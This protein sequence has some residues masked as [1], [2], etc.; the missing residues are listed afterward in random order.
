MIK[1]FSFI[2]ISLITFGCQNSNQNEKRNSLNKNEILDTFS[3]NKKW[4]NITLKQLLGIKGDSLRKVVLND[5]NSFAK[6]PKD[7]LVVNFQC[8]D[9]CGNSPIERVDVSPLFDDI[10]KRAIEFGFKSV[11][12][13]TTQ[14]LLDFGLRSYG[15]LPYYNLDIDAYENKVHVSQW[16]IYKPKG[17]ELVQLLKT[18]TIKL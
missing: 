7:T 10:K 18:H 14:D 1:L 15:N 6:V 4:S 16:Y 11:I 2:I 5:I 17:K 13:D 9:F 8:L 12:K 3:I